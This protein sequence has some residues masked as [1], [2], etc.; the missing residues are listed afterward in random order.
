VSCLLQT[1]TGD[2]DLSSGNLVLVDDTDG[3]AQQVAQE[4]NNRFALWLG[5]WFGDTRLGVP[6]VDF[7]LV[8]NPDMTVVGNIFSQIIT[9]TPGVATILSGSVDFDPAARTLAATYVVQLDNGAIL[10]GG[11]GVPFIVTT[12]VS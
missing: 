5:E 10:T 2:L 12:A 11:P 9:S 8:K 7:V 4:L 3:L 6:F 1:T